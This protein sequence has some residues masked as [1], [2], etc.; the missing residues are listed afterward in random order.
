[1]ITL[2]EVFTGLLLV[3][4]I[5]LISLQIYGFLTPKYPALM[6]P[7]ILATVTGIAGAVAVYVFYGSLWAVILGAVAGVYGNWG[8]LF[9]VGLVILEVMMAAL[10]KWSW[11]KDR[12]IDYTH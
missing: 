1:M 4:W 12:Y 2:N 3:G 5:A 8:N 6:L 7:A 11:D 10:A 9:I